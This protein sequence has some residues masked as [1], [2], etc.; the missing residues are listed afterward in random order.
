MDSQDENRQQEFDQEVD[1]VV[2]KSKR[3]LSEGQLKALADGRRKRWEKKRSKTSDVSAISEETPSDVDSEL[4]NEERKSEPSNSESEGS[5]SESD[6][7]NVSGSPDLSSSG[8]PSGSD[9]ASDSTSDND[10][11]VDEKEEIPSPPPT[12]K[13]PKLSP[14]MGKNERA[15]QKM[16]KYIAKTNSKSGKIL[17]SLVFMKYKKNFKLTK[18]TQT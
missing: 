16:N 2:R 14:G 11:G 5:G 18:N 17:R 12:P 3:K 15:V 10:S 1:T 8:N 9:S 13:K 7:S 4:K 6:G